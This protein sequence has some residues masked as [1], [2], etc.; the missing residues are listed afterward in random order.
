M[1]T[2]FTCFAFAAGLS[3]FAQDARAMCGAMLVK[4]QPRPKPTDPGAVAASA[5]LTN[6]ATKVIMVREGDAT[7]VTMSND[8]DGDV[9]EFG[10]VV[11]V[12]SVVTKEDV[13]LLEARIFDELEA[14]TAPELVEHYDP[15]PCPLPM[16]DMAS[17]MAPKATAAAEASPPA[18]AAKRKASDYGVKVESHFAAG[19]YDIAVLSGKDSERLIEWL[20]LFKYDV[21]A[22]AA[23]VIRTYLAQKTYFLVA[24]VDVRKMQREGRAFLRP[25]Q[26]KTKSPKFM[27]P[28][29]LGM[30]NADGPQELVVYAL[31]PAGRVEPTNYRSARLPTELHLPPVVKDRFSDL[32]R[33]AFQSETD[34]QDMRVVF[35]EW[36]G[37]TLGV[38]DPTTVGA[39]GAGPERGGAPWMLSRLHFLYDE[40]HFPEDLVLQATADR[41]YFA[42]RHHVTHPWTGSPDACAEA[43]AYFAQLSARQDKE[44][45]ALAQYTGWPIARAR[46]EAGL[47]ET[48]ATT[49]T[50]TTT[51][52]PVPTEPA[53]TPWYKRL[54]GD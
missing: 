22:K 28:I 18:P 45:V 5:R 13:Q 44:A 53:K 31:S 36:S 38:V 47:P 11:P 39:R 27:L 29:R 3:L 19:E 50:T 25:M 12:P 33:T 24:H 41:Q 8:F 37:S 16:D 54:W 26:M 43:K 10:L 52:Q 6:K 2:Q 51:T 49:T 42:V 14:G 40:A 34:R 7:V 35:T 32:Q 48:P 1:R 20:R 17:A 4:E 23:S 15:D 21:P 30:V 46:R 9:L